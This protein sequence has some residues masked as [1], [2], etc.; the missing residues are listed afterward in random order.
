MVIR[1]ALNKQVDKIGIYIKKNIILFAG[2]LLLGIVAKANP[3]SWVELYFYPSGSDQDVRYSI[4]INDNVVDAHKFQYCKK[5]ERCTF[6][7]VLTDEEIE[8]VRKLVEGLTN[9]SQA[10]DINSMLALDTWEMKLMIDGKLIYNKS[11]FSF[12]QLPAALKPL[13]D[14]IVKIAKIKIEL[15]GFA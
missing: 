1:K 10:D 7:K 4:V 6:S 11:D 8:N 5:R 2:I 12:E 14:Y 3:G 15:Y 13:I 9:Y